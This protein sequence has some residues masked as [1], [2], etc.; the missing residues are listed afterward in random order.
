MASDYTTLVTSGFRNKPK[1]METVGL[2]TGALGQIY[3]Q[4]LALTDAF[5]VEKA[6]GVQL[7]AVGLWVGIT[8]NQRIP[9]ADAFFSF[10][11]AGLGWNQANWKGPFEPTE[12]IVTLDDE[13]YRAVIFG[14]IGSNY[15][16][17]SLVDLNQIG[18]TALSDLNVQCFVLDNFDMSIVVYILGAPTAALLEM[19]KRGVIPPKPAG[20]RI[21]GYIL[22]SDPDAPFF[23]LSVFTTT[24][25]AGLDFGSFGNPV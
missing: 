19:I 5:S 6:V 24:E 3:D 1:F 18:E 8:R 13:T 4:T 11:V 17:G 15:W 23:A 25:V 20:V 14:K 7:D 21:A 10:N 16:S 9:I 2:L 12:G 22:A